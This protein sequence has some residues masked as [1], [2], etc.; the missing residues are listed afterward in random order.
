[1]LKKTRLDRLKD[2]LWVI[3]ATLTDLPKAMM[4]EHGCGTVYTQKMTNVSVEACFHQWKTRSL[5]V[6]LFWKENL[7]SPG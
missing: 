6:S 4:D 3:S 5:A 2:A 1:M 7:L